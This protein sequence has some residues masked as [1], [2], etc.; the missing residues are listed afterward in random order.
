MTEDDKTARIRT[1]ND[2]LRTTGEGGRVLIT[3]GIRALGTE[4]TALILRA[5]VTFDDFSPDNDPYG[6]H[7]CAVLTAHGHK[8]IWKIDYYD[9]DLRGH[10]PDPSNPSVTTRVLTVM[11]AKEY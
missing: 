10:S 3:E 7:D 6:E 2:R 4:M 11:L 9:T 5:V 1:L 8:V